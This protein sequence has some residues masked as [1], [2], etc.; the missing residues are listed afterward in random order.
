M[1]IERYKLILRLKYKGFSYRDIGKIFDISHQRVEQIIN[2]RKLN[3][4]VKKRIK[5]LERDNYECQFCFDK[6]DIQI[7]HIDRNRKNNKPTNLIVLCR[8]CHRKLHAGFVF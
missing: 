8:E 5:I 3:N 6:N 2:N 1:D 7:H 4:K